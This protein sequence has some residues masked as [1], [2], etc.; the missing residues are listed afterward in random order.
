MTKKIF[1][2]GVLFLISFIIVAGGVLYSFK[3]KKVDKVYAGTGE[4][5][6]GYAWSENI[7]WIS[8]NSINCDTDGNG[9]SN[10]GTGCPPAGT[11][12]GSYGVNILENAS[13]V[14]VLSGYAWS[15][16]IG[17]ISFNRSDTVAPPNNDV[18]A[19]YNV[20]AYIDSN[21]KLQGWARAIAV[22]DSVPCATSGAGTNSGGWD[23]WIRLNNNS[24]YGITLNP[25][26]GASYFTGWAWGSDVLGWISSNNA[27]GG[28]S[29]AYKIATTFELNKSPSISGTSVSPKYCS[30]SDSPSSYLTFNWTFND[31]NLNSANQQSKYQIDISYTGFSY[32]TGQVN[33][34]KG[35]NST[36]SANINLSNLGSWYGK[37]LNW[38]LTVWDNGTYQKSAGAN[39]TFGP[40]P[41]REYPYVT[42][43]S[44]PD[45]SKIFA[46]QD[47]QFSPDLFSTDVTK[48]FSSGNTSA[49]SC[50]SWSWNFT[51][52]IPTYKSPATS[53]SKDPIL[54]FPDA[55]TTPVT[56]TLTATDSAGHSCS[57]LKNISSIG[58][59]LPEFKEQKK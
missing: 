1:K 43:Y 31:P 50:S 59:P 49:P 22:C 10:G 12:M 34:P 13:S 41:D 28:G 39:G 11:V 29:T 51:G 32:S 20:L 37:T 48:C 57:A 16:N 47:I 30:S 5:V 2:L 21:N 42:F 24:T 7:G 19:S 44:N 33:Y 52:A 4:N 8:F 46:N 17:W 45:M 14:G 53:T 23:G 3:N 26:S 38:T 40:L 15:E 55:I 54:K 27:T 18:G 36:N 25:A 35:N 56:V 6:T 58:L 9:Q